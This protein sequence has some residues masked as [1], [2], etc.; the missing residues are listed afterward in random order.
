MPRALSAASPLQDPHWMD[1]QQTDYWA[2]SAA[3]QKHPLRIQ[4][5]WCHLKENTFIGKRFFSITKNPA[6]RWNRLNGVCLFY[7]GLIK[8]ECRGAEPKPEAV[9]FRIA[10]KSGY[11]GW[12]QSE[13][14]RSCSLPNLVRLRQLSRSS[15]PAKKLRPC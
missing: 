1:N 5:S 11:C 13:Q 2:A 15:F 4:I 8:Y 7:E 6:T 10:H 9:P 14:P 3:C 12:H